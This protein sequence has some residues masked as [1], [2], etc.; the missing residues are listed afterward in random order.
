VLTILRAKLRERGLQVA[1]EADADPELME[2]VER[3]RQKDDFGNGRDV[4]T[5]ADKAYKAQACRDGVD[6]DD[7]AVTMTDLRVALAEMLGSVTATRAQRPQRQEGSAGGQRPAIDT[8][9]SAPP[10]RQVTRQAT[11]QRADVLA[12][13][14][15]DGPADAPDGDGGNGSGFENMNKQVLQTLQVILDEAGVTS[16]EGARRFTKADPGSAEYKRL[17]N[18]LRT[19]LGMSPQEATAQ[20]EE[21][22]GAHDS[23]EDIEKEAATMKKTKKLEAIW[24]C[25]VCG[26]ADMPWIACYVAPYIVGYRKV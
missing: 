5:W 21:W 10:P 1:E 23:L 9:R 24:R 25:Q 20:L 3:L 12:K 2:L 8:H 22:R 15:E 4:A 7:T 18:R 11:A 14:D 16:L 26:R 6:V 17:F 19:D 13:E